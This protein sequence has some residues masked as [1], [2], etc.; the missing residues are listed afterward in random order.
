MN[1]K[2]KTITKNP[3]TNKLK[4]K[5]INMNKQNISKI[6]HPYKHKYSLQIRVLNQCLQFQHAASNYYIIHKSTNTK[7]SLKKT[8]T[9]VKTHKFI[10]SKRRHVCPKTEMNL[11]RSEEMKYCKEHTVS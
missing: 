10:V 7:F 2:L 1:V 6:Q 3:K 8:E 9:T 11:C 4:P 5:T